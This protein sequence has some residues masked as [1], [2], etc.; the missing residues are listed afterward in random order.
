[1]LYYYSIIRCIK[2]SK[3]LANVLFTLDKKVNIDCYDK[4]DYSKYDYCD[5]LNNEKFHNKTHI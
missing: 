5:A 2:C 4:V 1:M 3:S